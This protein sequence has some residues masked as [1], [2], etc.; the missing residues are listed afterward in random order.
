M[1][2]YGCDRLIVGRLM[3]SPSAAL[4]LPSIQAAARDFE[5]PL[6]GF[7]VL[8]YSASAAHQSATTKRKP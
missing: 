5:M 3:G 2:G 4:G 8:T 6:L 7:R 1:L